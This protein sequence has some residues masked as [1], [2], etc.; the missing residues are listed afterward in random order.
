[1][2]HNLKK[3]DGTIEAVDC[4]LGSGVFDKNGKEIFEGD[5]IRHGF[6]RKD[7]A[8]VT[9]QNGA[10]RFAFYFGD[11]TYTEVPPK[12]ASTFEVIGRHVND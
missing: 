1:M 7:T 9:F 6:D 11:K 8:V 4:K 2:I 3:P 5:I 10:F 12:F